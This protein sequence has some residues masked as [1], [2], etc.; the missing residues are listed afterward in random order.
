MRIT[1][2]RNLRK[3]MLRNSLLSCI[4]A[5]LIDKNIRKTGYFAEW[6]LVIGYYLTNY[7]LPITKE[8]AIYAS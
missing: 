8:G 1:T 3:K 7:H 2:T 4:C 6:R 5:F